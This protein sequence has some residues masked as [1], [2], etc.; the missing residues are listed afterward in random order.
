MVKWFMLKTY[1]HNNKFHNENKNQE[2]STPFKYISR[3]KRVDINNLLNRVRVEKKNEIKQ[4]IIFYCSVV[5]MIGFFM[6][7]L[8]IF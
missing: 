3:Q 2:I 6:T 5:L 1:L 7:F 4:K 8:T